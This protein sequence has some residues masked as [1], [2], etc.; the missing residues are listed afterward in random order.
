MEKEG[1][2]YQFSLADVYI[3]GLE[4]FTETLNSYVP[5]WLG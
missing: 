2:F 4:D 3:G 1:A 5:L